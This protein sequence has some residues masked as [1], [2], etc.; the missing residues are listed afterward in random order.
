MSNSPKVFAAFF[1]AIGLAAGA[2]TIGVLLLQKGG[3]V[4]PYMAMGRDKKH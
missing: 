3:H 1:L 4:S 2:F